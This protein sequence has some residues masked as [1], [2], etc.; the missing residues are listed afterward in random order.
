MK[1]DD[2]V[3]YLA[4]LVGVPVVNF[5]KVQF[6]L[7]GKPAMFLAIG[8]SVV[9]A[10]FALAVTGGFDASDLLGAASKVLATATVVYKLLG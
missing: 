7:S 2:F 4:G 1:F 3:M 9:L 6:N 8:V 5:L 10:A